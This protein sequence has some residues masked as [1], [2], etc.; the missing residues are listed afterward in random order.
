M[1]L[2]FLITEKNRRVKPDTIGREAMGL[3][4]NRF[5]QK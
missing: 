2:V 3:R 5:R 1:P 4:E